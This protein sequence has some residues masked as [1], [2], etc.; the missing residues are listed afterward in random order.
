MA[1][2]CT[3]REAAQKMAT[4][5]VDAVVVVE[6]DTV[7]GIFTERDAVFRVIAQALDPA[8]TTLDDVMTSQ[9]LTVGPDNTF[10]YALQLMQQRGFRHIPVV[11]SGKPVGIVS[12]RDAL[13]PEMEQ[14]NSEVKR[15]QGIRS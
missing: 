3:V 8:V 6:D 15:R 2:G 12:S 9:P 11:E 14:F 5:N 4:G 13:D 10:G 1:P 7:I